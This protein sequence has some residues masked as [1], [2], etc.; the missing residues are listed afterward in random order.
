MGVVMR[1][2]IAV[3]LFALYMGHSDAQG[4]HKEV[5]LKL[6]GQQLGADCHIELIKVGEVLAGNN[7]SRGEQWLVKTCKGE[8]RFWVEYWP[9]QKIPYQVTER[10]W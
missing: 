10:E 1:N 5:W 8:V 9:N 2:V 4:G 7:G 3:M 6:I